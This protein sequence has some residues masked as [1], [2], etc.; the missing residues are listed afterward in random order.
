MKTDKI[1]IPIDCKEI[2]NFKRVFDMSFFKGNKEAPN[3]QT[4]ANTANI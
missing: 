4:V 1:T 3:Q 2:S